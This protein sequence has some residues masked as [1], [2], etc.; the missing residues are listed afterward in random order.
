MKIF[1]FVI[2]VLLTFSCK[3]DEPVT[4]CEDVTTKFLP[5]T[6]GS[7]WIYEWFEINSGPSLNLFDTIRITSLEEIDSVTYA[8][9]D[10][11]FYGEDHFEFSFV[12]DTNGIFKLA[13]IDSMV[14]SPNGNVIYDFRKSIYNVEPEFME[15]FNLG[16]FTFSTQMNDCFNDYWDYG[17]ELDLNQFYLKSTNLIGFDDFDYINYSRFGKNIGEVSR[18]YGFSLQVPS[19]A[20]RKL[21]EYHIE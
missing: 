21:I 20:T 9:Y 1:L 11:T 5:M 13:E 7:Y 2:I 4:I 19:L 17:G 18:T 10:G 15:V 6:V 8:V 14:Y 16:S 12:S 3:K